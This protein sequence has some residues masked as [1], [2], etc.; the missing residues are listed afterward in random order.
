MATKTVIVNGKEVSFNGWSI[1]PSGSGTGTVT[2][3]YMIKD[4]SGSS[5]SDTT[6]VTITPKTL[7][8]EITKSATLTVKIDPPTNKVTFSSSD[9][10]I[11]SVDATGNV[12][13]NTA[14]IAKITAT[15]MD[16]DVSK[17]KS[18]TCDVTVKNLAPTPVTGIIT[19]TPTLA[20]QVGDT[21]QFDINVEPPTATDKVVTYVSDKPDV[22]TVN[23][24][25]LVTGVSPGNA[26]I[27][28]T[29]NDGSKT[30]VCNVT[31]TFVEIDIGLT[32]PTVPTPTKTYF[33]PFIDAH[34][35][36]F[37]KPQT[38]L[39]K[40][41]DITFT[42]VVTPNYEVYPLI[43]VI[44][45]NGHDYSFALL[46]ITAGDFQLDILRAG[47]KIGQYNV[48]VPVIGGS[49]STHKNRKFRYTRKA[50]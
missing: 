37:S 8:L 34:V 9:D 10:K 47:I 13:G 42:S 7:T 44:K 38:I 45:N 4:S 1:T 25:G 28:A 19:S 3:N 31:V 23:T 5:S 6:S 30:V 15:S 49:R 20:L 50:S 41:E 48:K 16:T 14:G 43:P 35:I 33:L 40:I 27:T 39:G 46:P 32:A 22:A 17:Q 12:T 18:D 11:A 36:S 24:S 29:T 21:G 26:V 2:T